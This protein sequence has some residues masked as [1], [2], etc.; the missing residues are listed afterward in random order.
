MERNNIEAKKCFN[1]LGCSLLI[2]AVVT[3]LLQVVLLIASDGKA[4]AEA[5]WFLWVITFV[6]LYLIGIPL[7]LLSMKKLPVPEHGQ[8]SLGGKNFFLFL[9]MCFP[10]MYG[11]NL[12]GNLLAMAL[13]GGAA[14]NPLINYVFDGNQL[15]RVVVMAFLA[16]LFEEYLFRKQ[17]IDRCA[18]YGEKTA[19]LFSALAFALFHMN[20]YQFFYAFLLGLVFGYVYTCT[21]K[22]KYSVIMHMIINF[23]GSVVAPLLLRGIGEDNLN[24]MLSGEMD[25][26][27]LMSILPALSG[28]LIYF[29]ILIGLSIAGIIILCK[30]VPRLVFMPA[31]EEIPHSDCFKTVY[32]N[33]GVICFAVICVAFTVVNLLGGF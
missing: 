33:I 13:T 2:V 14:S 9:L 3:T 22:L 27:V 11:G 21:R 8:S 31:E 17:I 24:L 4:Y 15:F 1:N 20:L 19:I 30:K 7:G 12:I 25:E 5:S 18:Q 6:P 29:V 23:M 32:C 26:T 10:L 16:P 28:F